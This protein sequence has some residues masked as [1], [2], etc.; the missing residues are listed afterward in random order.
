MKLQGTQVIKFSEL[1]KNLKDM[2]G[3]CFLTRLDYDFNPNK[4]CSYSH[5]YKNLGLTWN[6][7]LEQAGIPIKRKLPL[8]STQGRKEKNKSKAKVVECLRCL[9]LFE[10]IDPC[11]NRICNKCHGLEDQEE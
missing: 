4:T 7:L 2:A 11:I 9:E 3:T 5:I 1:V 6:N 10:S 8:P